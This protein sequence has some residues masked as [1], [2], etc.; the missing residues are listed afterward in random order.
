MGQGRENSRVKQSRLCNAIGIEIGFDG[1][2]V[3]LSPRPLEPFRHG[4][5]SPAA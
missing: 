2:A 4:S 1:F 3:H 5:F